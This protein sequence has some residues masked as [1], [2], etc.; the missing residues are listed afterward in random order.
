MTAPTAPTATA[1]AKPKR[2][3][4][5]RA[6]CLMAAAA[7]LMLTMSQPAAA[8]TTEDPYLYLFVSET[9]VDGRLELS[10]GDLEQTL[11]LS[12]GDDDQAIKRSLD[13]Q[14]PAIRSYASQHLAIGADGVN[15][16][17]E[18][19]DVELFRE[20]DDLA[21]AVIPY[22]A[23]VPDD[24][25]PTDLDVRFDPFFDEADGRNG[26]LL[27]TGGWTAG[28]Y[29][30]NAESL[31]TFTGD[32]RQQAVG[33]GDRTQWQ[34]FTSSITLGIDHIRTGPDHIMF[35][36][37]LLLPSVLVFGR[38][39]QPVSGFLGA[40][41]RVLKIATFFT[42]AHSITFT[43]A[44]MGWLPLP[45]SQIVE[46]IIALSIAAAALHNLKPIF[47][48][49]EWTL[50]F[51]F[52]LFHGMGF[53][54]LVAELE[55]SRS[56]QLISLIGR[57]VG[58]ELGQVV[59]ILVAFPA[60]YLLRRTSWYQPLLTIGSIVL[61]VLSVSWMIERVF[62][63]DI[64]TDGIVEGL[65]QLPRGY[66]IAALATVVAIGVRTIEDRRQQLQPVAES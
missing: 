38:E 34:N 29:D 21:F 25:V 31:I 1:K 62:D 20:R 27:V 5:A 59:V 16:D 12:F 23:D 6:L 33:L 14:A 15:W 36:L 18:L 11:G 48:N 17:L 42:I 43:L 54:S 22:V 64:G 65:V 58:I 66:A 52:G 63:T 53:A 9:T 7:A 56:S 55:V 40:L 32:S 45:P 50:S 39:W 60:L 4:T 24:S 35:V 28:T 51:V 19:A 30:R 3:R 41:W 49:R 10:I 2:P 13:Q 57:N 61:A 8:H 46:S 37:A 26:L 44:G 47:P